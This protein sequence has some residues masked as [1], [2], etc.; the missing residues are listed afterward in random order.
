M[1]ANLS[2]AFITKPLHTGGRPYM[3][4]SGRL[5]CKTVRRDDL[6]ATTRRKQLAKAFLKCLMDILK[7]VDLYSDTNFPVVLIYTNNLS[8]AT[9][10]DRLFGQSVSKAQRKAQ[11]PSCNKGMI[12]QKINTRPTD[13]VRNQLFRSDVNWNFDTNTL[14][15]PL[16]NLIH[17]HHLIVIN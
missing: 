15:P 14:C 1:A 10:F 13:V 7:V 9:Y 2:L 6:V 16:F 3:R 17:S 5:C 4:I 11:S 12:N 8:L